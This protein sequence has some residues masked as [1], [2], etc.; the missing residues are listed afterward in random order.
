[1][2][3]QLGIG[4]EGSDIRTLWSRAAANRSHLW[5]VRNRRKII[6]LAGGATKEIVIGDESSNGGRPLRTARPRWREAILVCGKCIKRHDD[7]K[8]LRRAL[9]DAAKKR[10]AKGRT[11]DGTRRRKVRLIKTACLGLC[12]R[13]ALVV[14]SAATLT[15]GEVLVLRD[16]REIEAVLPRL[17]LRGADR[18]S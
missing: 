11:D 4:C 5:T 10:A 9:R 13:R 7:G 12:P 2:P 3:C 14:A 18:E 15:K 8:A 16:E 17:L 1:M 6:E